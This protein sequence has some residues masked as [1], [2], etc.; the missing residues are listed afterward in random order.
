MP[1]FDTYGIGVKR[2]KNQ[3]MR[4]GTVVTIG[5]QLIGA[6]VGDR[7]IGA[8]IFRRRELMEIGR[9]RGWNSWANM[10][11]E[12]VRRIKGVGPQNTAVNSD[13][14]HTCKYSFSFKIRDRVLVG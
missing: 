3:L 13:T 4:R 1:D 12:W 14:S 10:G 8:A 5:N 9:S 11:S 2:G 6:T 7:L